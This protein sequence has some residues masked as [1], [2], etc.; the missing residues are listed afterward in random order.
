MTETEIIQQIAQGLA[1]GEYSLLL[2][3]GASLGAVGGNGSE[4]PTG[5]G[6]R[7]ALVEEFNIDTGG[8]TLPL[9]QLYDYL[10]QIGLVREVN[11][12]MRAW[13]VD[14]RPSWQ[15]LFAEFNWKRIW[16][17]N[18]DDVIEKAFR[19][20][21]RSIESLTWNQRFSDRI[22]ASNQQIIHLHGLAERLP[23]D[24]TKSDALVFSLSDYAREV[25]NPRTWHKVFFDEFAGSPF[26]VIGAQLTQEIDLIDALNPGNAARMTTGFPSV[27]VVPNITQIRRTQLEASGFTIIESSGECFIN[28]LIEQFRE[29]ISEHDSVYGPSTPGLRRFLQQFIDL[30][31]YEP[32]DTNAGDFYSGYQPTWNTIRSGDDAMLDKTS[33]ISAGIIDLAMRDEVYQKLVFFTGRP[34][35]GKSTGLLRIAANLRTSGVF[36]F[37][38]RGD[39]YLDVEATNDWC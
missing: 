17:L 10:Q 27:V 37:L 8:E 20:T 14:C 6:L 33:Q 15:H 16:T 4:L 1:Y 21:G 26:L 23:D 36:P 25:A 30:R 19:E 9:P 11:A 18:I 2:G 34:G 5:A 29:V 24:G 7:D 12:F 13:F 22:S 39:E 31:T 35:S 3:A 28:K 32:S 38:F